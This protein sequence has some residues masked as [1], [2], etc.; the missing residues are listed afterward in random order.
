M[1]IP[2]VDAQSGIASV[3]NPTLAAL[4]P[5]L[6]FVLGMI[7]AFFVVETILDIIRGRKEDHQIKETLDT[8][9]KNMEL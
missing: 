5:V 9:H 2:T 4:S 3:V 8:L 7:F 6:V 1:L